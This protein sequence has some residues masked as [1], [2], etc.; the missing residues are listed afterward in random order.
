MAV[1]GATEYRQ[2]SALQP[3]SERV[4]LLVRNTAIYLMSRARSI[5]K[6]QRRLHFPFYHHVFDDERQ[7]FARQ[8]KYMR[9]FGEFLGLDDAVGLLETGETIDGRY[10]CVT[11][12]DGYR[13]CLT[14]ALPI[15]LEQGC[16]AAIFLPT[17]YIGLSLE[18]AWQ[19]AQH[20]A[21]P[22]P[23]EFLTWD[24]CRQLANAGII[25]IGAHTHTHAALALLSA[26]E[27]RQELTLAKARI[28]QELG[29][30]CSH[31]ACPF[32]V[33][34]DHFRVD[35]DPQIARAVG[36]RS[37]C[38]VERG[39]N[40]T[41]DDPFHIRRDYLSSDWGNDQLRYFLV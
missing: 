20:W 41:G 1:T 2:I 22:L 25:T 15:L 13:N 21:L 39:A 38:T 18:Q 6:S 31:F 23:V 35:R 24:D 32:G 12:D 11:F 10:F 9:Q 34:G 36:Y 7:G 33:P 37:F 30:P 16:P 14:N 26:E 19:T 29:G 8:L 4:R 28:E 17:Q 40:R 27:A 3:L 5:E